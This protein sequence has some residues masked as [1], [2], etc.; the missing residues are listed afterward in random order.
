MAKAT[1]DYVTTERV[2]NKAVAIRNSPEYQKEGEGN[3]FDL[4]I[5]DIIVDISMMHH[6]MKQRN[7]VDFIKFYSKHNTGR[8]SSN[9]LFCYF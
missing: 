7:P 9:S 6:G 3:V 4:N 2:F 5:D 1:E 8:S